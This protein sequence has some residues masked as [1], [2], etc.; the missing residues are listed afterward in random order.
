VREEGK[1]LLGEKKT[2][3]ERRR[4]IVNSRARGR[5]EKKCL[6]VSSLALT[7]TFPCVKVNAHAHLY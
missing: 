1:C 7:C 6:E 4:G 3:T 5:G 2:D